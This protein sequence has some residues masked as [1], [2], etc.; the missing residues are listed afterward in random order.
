[1]NNLKNIVFLIL[2][3]LCTNSVLSANDLD[4]VKAMMKDFIKNDE[5]GLL[6]AFYNEN[7]DSLTVLTAGKINEEN[8]LRLG[9]PT[10][11]SCISYI[12]LH[13]GI[14]LDT[15][16]SSW[17]PEENGYTKSDSISL[18]MLLYNTSGI[19][20][21]I[22]YINPNEAVTPLETIQLA[23]Q[24]KNLDFEPGKMFQYSNTNY[25]IL[26]VI[27]EN[28][29]RKDFNSII[30]EYFGNISPSLRM[31]DGKGNYPTGY[32]NPWP[33]HWSAPGYAGGLISTAE[34][35]IKVFSYISDQPEFEQMTDWIEDQTKSNH[36][37]GKG[38]FG[39]KNFGDFG[40]VVYYDGDLMANQMLLMKIKNTVY[41][42][43]TTY[44][45]G[46]ENLI[47]FAK[48]IVSIVQP[49]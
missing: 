38:I 2:L 41:Y 10:T 4:S 13:Q 9:C 19:Q 42:F 16:I 40:T 22:K 48:Q 46:L 32:K 34:D 39:F 6:F 47:N 21:Y 43:H 35:A 29:M 25:N 31:D 28:V 14:D 1:M 5:N 30:K 7:K 8:D 44:P 23:Y 37:V 27:I 12:Y 3:L 49:I 20:E 11:K 45:A 18:R 15:K 26:S 33:Y 24:N 17:F 36:L